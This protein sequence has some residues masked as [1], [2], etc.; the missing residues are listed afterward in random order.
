MF[1][2]SPPETAN[3]PVIHHG[4]DDAE[5][6]VLHRTMW[7]FP[8]QHLRTLMMLS[9]LLTPLE[10]GLKRDRK[11]LLVRLYGRLCYTK[12][13]VSAYSSKIDCGD[14]TAYH[15][16]RFSSSGDLIQSWVC[17]QKPQLDPAGSQC[18]ADC[19]RLF[20]FHSSCY[21]SFSTCSFYGQLH[22]T[23]VSIARR[24]DSFGGVFDAT[25]TKQKYASASCSAEP[26]TTVCWPQTPPIHI[27]D[28]GPKDQVRTSLVNNQ[29]EQIIRAME[30]PIRY[31][32]LPRPRARSL[33]LDPRIEHLLASTLSL[34]NATN[35]SL[36]SDC[37]LCPALE[38]PWP[39]ALPI[40]LTLESTS[41]D[42]CTKE[43]PFK[44]MPISPGLVTCIESPPLR[45]MSSVTSW[46]CISIR[47]VNSAVLCPPLGQVF[48][49]GGNLAFPFFTHQLNRLLFSGPVAPGHRHSPGT[50]THSTPQPR[51]PGPQN[52]QSGS[53]H[54]TVARARCFWR[55]GHWFV[56][57]GRRPPIL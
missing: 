33:D 34:L 15:Q 49:C 38:D 26:E 54:P 27:T 37:W 16:M 10:V 30:P 6:M 13:A 1:S 31:N 7:V 40:N 29:V 56:W 17:M 22:F 39:L 11:A 9:C 44:V 19:T 47:P 5:P 51:H 12:E 23:A 42:N 46:N 14:K 50:H 41:P 18:P 28:D 35:P 32:S 36:A 43:S 45:L 3:N 21:S 4:P 20:K 52:D 55:R 48:V 2:L 8:H 24:D 57:D 25:N 53:I